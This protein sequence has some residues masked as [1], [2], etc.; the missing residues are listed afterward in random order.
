MSYANNLLANPAFVSS[1]KQDTSSWTKNWSSWSDTIL[2][3]V[4]TSGGGFTASVAYPEVGT[5]TVDQMP[6]TAGEN[7]IL[8]FS[9]GSTLKVTVAIEATTTVETDLTGTISGIYDQQD[10]LWKG[11][12]ATE[13]IVEHKSHMPMFQA[14]P[15][16]SVVA[17]ANQID[18]VAQ[19]GFDPAIHKTETGGTW[20][21]QYAWGYSADLRL[22]NHANHSTQTH[23][24]YPMVVMLANTDRY[25]PSQVLGS[26]NGNG[27]NNANSTRDVRNVFSPDLQ[28]TVLQLKDFNIPGYFVR[29]EHQNDSTRKGGYWWVEMYLFDGGVLKQTF[30]SPTFFLEVT[31]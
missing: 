26:M 8:V 19:T 11:I 28:T 21:V 4:V 2:Q 9:G 6:R 14:W 27:Q 7:D 31:S 17:R 30:Y 29:G 23:L 5:V 18:F 25:F 1:L 15:K 16:D 12:A 13:K 3:P 20:V 22:G 24:D 10:S